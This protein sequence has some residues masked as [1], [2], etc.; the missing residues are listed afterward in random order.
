MLVRYSWYYC[1]NYTP[2]SEN[3][4]SKISF[5]LIALLIVPKPVTENIPH[6]FS[7]IW[8]VMSVPPENLVTPLSH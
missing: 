6:R 3:M 2:S 4:I 7:V 5:E 1:N 8:N